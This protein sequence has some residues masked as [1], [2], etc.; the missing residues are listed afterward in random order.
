MFNTHNIV[1]QILMSLIF[2]IFTSA[3]LIWH[4]YG[5]YMVLE[6]FSYKV[7]SPKKS[8]IKWMKCFQEF[9]FISKI[10][11][12]NFKENPSFFSFDQQLFSN[13][14][15]T[16]FII[17]DKVNKFFDTHYVFSSDKMFCFFKISISF[18]TGSSQ[19]IVGNFIFHLSSIIKFTKNF[20]KS[21]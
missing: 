10:I 12:F 6:N 17:G 14:T 7:F 9:L 11:L 8:N 2:L 21:F 18:L 15:Y 13:C 20:M 5:Q 1:L 3:R 19:D 4:I 16:L